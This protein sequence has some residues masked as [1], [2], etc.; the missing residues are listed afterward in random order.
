MKLILLI[1]GQEPSVGPSIDVTQPDF[2]YKHF[3]TFIHTLGHEMRCARQTERGGK[4][5]GFLV[6]FVK[7]G[8]RR[9]FRPGTVKRYK[10]KVRTVCAN[11]HLLPS[12]LYSRL[13]LLVVD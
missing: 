7:M 2:I 12:I 4:S 11:S 10:Y 6:Y 5:M 3:P 13:I 9:K 1:I 8:S